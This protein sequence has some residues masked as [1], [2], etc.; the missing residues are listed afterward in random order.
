MIAS[1]MFL[2]SSCGGGNSTSDDSASN[3]GALSFNVVYHSASDKGQQKATVIDCAG[4]GVST[5]EAA[6]YD[7]D[8][9]LLKR[10]GPWDCAAGQGT[11]ASVPAGS[12]RTVVILEKNADGKVV[13]RGEK[14]DIDVVANNENN[15]GTI[16]CNDFVPNL[17]APVNGAAVEAGA[18][19]LEWTDVNGATEYSV[20]VWNNSDLNNPIIDDI[21]TSAN[22]MPTG[23]FYERI[24]YWQIV[25]VDSA[26]NTGIASEIWSFKS[27]AN[28]LPVAQITIP[29]KGSTYTINENI[30]FAGTGS[31]NEDGD[32]SGKSLVWNSDL[33]GQIGTGETF[34]SIRFS[35]GTHHITLTATDSEEA[36]GFDTLVITIATGRLPDTGQKE[37]Q[38]EDYTPTPGEDMTLS[39]NPPA[40][41]KLN[42]FG[43]ELDV[44]TTDWTMVRDD[45][46]GL[47][48]E[49]K[50][51]DST[52]HSRKEVYTWEEAQDAQ[53]GF[54]A[55]LNDENFGGFTDWR[56]PTIKELYTL[57]HNIKVDPDAPTPTIN[58]DYFPNTV[59]LSYWSSTTN[60]GNTS[61]VWYVNFRSGIISMNGKARTYYV[62]A[63]RGGK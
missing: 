38:F 29:A 5:V 3:T 21:T 14:S 10:G 13:F 48:W 25:A 31:D 32:L 40:Y 43:E 12:D 9:A 36:T 18:M 47:I 49:A 59:S 42:S 35:A 55:Q 26:G 23:L 16:V 57:V 52:I 33:Y 8:D 58:T 27:P 20:F 1:G 53:N 24:Y 56:L 50:T 62:R 11:I 7:P 19:V 45:V 46:T 60:A 4:E 2:L 34:T 30:E 54:I 15:A 28:T 41:T 63:V 61:S 22:F 51:D 39:I 17:L 37:S 44:S 6:V